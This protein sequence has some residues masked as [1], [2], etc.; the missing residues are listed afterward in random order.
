MKRSAI[1]VILSGI[2]LI[3]VNC[4]HA[5]WGKRGVEKYLKT[6][7]VFKVGDHFVYT[8]GGHGES[9]VNI[10]GLKSVLALLPV[11]IKMAYQIHL[12]G[13]KP[14]VIVGVPHG[15]DVLASQVAIFYSLFSSC[16]CLNLKLMKDGEKFV[17]YKDHGED[18]RGKVILVIEDVAN[19]GGSL[20]KCGMFIKNHGCSK[21]G[22]FVVCDRL[23]D[24]NPGLATLGQ[25]IRADYTETLVSVNA[26]NYTIPE[27]VNPEEYCPYCKKGI[28]INTQIG[29]GEKFLK[30]IKI[31]FPELYKKLS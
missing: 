28:K 10:K 2:M 18:A 30:R 31:T 16:S 8:K 3:L 22:L 26:A 23:S 13:F 14:D 17:W 24:K 9:Y 12:S 1:E 25:S 4:A 11:S 29:H 5:V 20:V 15:A 21:F 7:G 6:M 19:T 27:G